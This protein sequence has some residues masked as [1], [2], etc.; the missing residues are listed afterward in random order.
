MVEFKY[1][2]YYIYL[3]FVASPSA[4]QL[5]VP[6]APIFS[7]LPE[8][9]HVI[10]M[11]FG[12]H[13]TRDLAEEFTIASMKP[14]F[15]ILIPLVSDSQDGLPHY[16]L[17]LANFILP[18]HKNEDIAETT[19]FPFHEAD[20]LAI[21]ESSFYLRYQRDEI[22][23]QFI[24]PKQCE[25]PPQLIRHEF[26]ELVLEGALLG[27]HTGKLFFCN[28]PPYTT[29]AEGYCSL[30]E[31]MREDIGYLFPNVCTVYSSQ[32]ERA[33]NTSFTVTGITQGFRDMLLLGGKNIDFF[34]SE[35]FYGNFTMGIKYPCV[36]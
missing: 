15:Y 24:I 30:M 31:G 22:R 28:P 36:Q 4:P 10:Y 23:I 17:P 18:S 20:E 16:S 33:C 6:R 26:D 3:I 8:G 34:S 25:R 32:D 11:D 9:K 35:M 12:Y 5:Y 7:N 21:S 27:S 19:L 1:Y 29:D 2:I 14:M 13:L